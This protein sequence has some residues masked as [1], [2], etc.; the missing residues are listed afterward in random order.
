MSAVGIKTWQE[1]VLEGP[2]PNGAFARDAE[3]AELRAALEDSEQSRRDLL[4]AAN[5]A[6]GGD[7]FMGEPVLRAVEQPV[8]AQLKQTDLSQRLRH[9]DKTEIATIAASDLHA[10]A[11]EIDRYYNGMLAWKQTAETK[12]RKLS[13]EMTDRINERVAKRIAE[14]NADVVAHPVG[15]VVAWMTEDGE[16]VVSAGTMARAESDGG[17]T[18]SGLRP[19]SVPLTPA[20]A[21]QPAKPADV[22]GVVAWEYCPECGCLET[23]PPEEGV[24]FY[25]FNCGQEW[26]GDVDYSKTVRKNLSRLAALAAQTAA[27]ADVGGVKEKVAELHKRSNVAHGRQDDGSYKGDVDFGELADIASEALNLLDVLAAQTA[28]PVDN[29]PEGWKRAPDGRLIPPAGSIGEAYTAGEQTAAPGVKVPE[30]WALVRREMTDDQA[31]EVVYNI[32]RKYKGNPVSDFLAREVW[33][34]AIYAKPAAPQPVDG[35]AGVKAETKHDEL[36][37]LAQNAGF[38]LNMNGELVVPAPHYDARKYLRKFA[39]L[40]A[41]PAP[42]APVDLSGLLRWGGG[43]CDS[44]VRK[45]DT[46]EFVLLDDVRALLAAGGKGGT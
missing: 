26:H 19:Y 27:P 9:W 40:L 28:A 23:D 41:A 44:E 31:K 29:L 22:G 18:L 20:L 14:I 11:D 42:A 16:R 1:R 6:I 45:R 2:Q 21:T 43:E 15:A 33:K 30:G 39:K 13:E 38:V 7:T 37:R 17:A 10:A 32:N 46:G 24:G 12:D 4:D 35:A 25:C 34:W 3:I 36:S 8:G 5:R